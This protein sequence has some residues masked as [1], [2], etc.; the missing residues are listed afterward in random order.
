MI[1]Y[2]SCYIAKFYLAEP[3]SASVSARA[4]REGGVACCHHGKLETA[5]VFHRKLREGALTLTEYHLLRAQFESDCAMGMW[6]WLPVTAQLMEDAIRRYGILSAS[7]WLRSADAL[8]LTCAAAHG[9]GEIFTSDRHLLAAA[10]H[11]GLTG[12]SL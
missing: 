9:F 1:Y 11:F 10:P 4:V 3:D 12:T 2:D 5:A 6:W 7:A 8:H